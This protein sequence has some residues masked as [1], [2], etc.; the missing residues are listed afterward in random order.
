M[1]VL[2][3]RRHFD[4]DGVLVE[5][6]DIK[7]QAFADLYQSYGNTI[8]NEVVRYHKLNGGLSRYKKFRYFQQYLLKKP[9]LT[10]D[11]EEIRTADVLQDLIQTVR[12]LQLIS[13]VCIRQHVQWH[14]VNQLPV[15]KPLKDYIS[16]G[17]ISPDHVI[18]KVITDNVCH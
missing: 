8:V 13:R 2:Y 7:T 18:H 12:P 4:F 6:G 1:K 3:A 5:S 10:Q 15:P 14:D 11:E 9:P 17:D 16:F